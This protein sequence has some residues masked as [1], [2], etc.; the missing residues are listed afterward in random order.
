MHQDSDPD[1]RQPNVEP[2]QI[3]Q[4]VPQRTTQGRKGKTEEHV[5][6]ICG[7]FIRKIQK[8]LQKKTKFK[9]T[10]NRVTP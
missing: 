2:F 9:L 7:R 10:S 1:M 4:K 3:V 6:P 8:N 5:Y